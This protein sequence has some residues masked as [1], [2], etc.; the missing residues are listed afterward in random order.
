MASGILGSADLA[1]TTNTSV[2]TV[3]TGK[4]ASFSVNVCNRNSTPVTIRLAFAASGTPSAGEWLEYDAPLPANGILER[5]GLMMDASKILVAYSS[6]ASVSV[7][8]YGIEE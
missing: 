8:V 1:A 3:P 7:L 5:S 4:V 6:G 2:Y